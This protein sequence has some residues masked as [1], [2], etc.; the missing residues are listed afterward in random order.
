MTMLG[1]VL[2]KVG[3]GD[4]RSATARVLRARVALEN[5]S[6]G[7]LITLGRYESS[8]PVAEGNLTALIVGAISRIS[9]N[10]LQKAYARVGESLAMVRKLAELQESRRRMRADVIE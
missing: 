8:M 4:M 7:R 9:K 10:D 1:S 3:H 6:E 2:V 5:M